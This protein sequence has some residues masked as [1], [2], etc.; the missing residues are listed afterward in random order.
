MCQPM[1]YCHMEDM[2]KC[3]HGTE[4]RDKTD[5]PMDGINH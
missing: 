3:N 5:E 2:A 1:R 4:I